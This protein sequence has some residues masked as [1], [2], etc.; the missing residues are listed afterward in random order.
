MRTFALA[1]ALSASSAAYAQAVCP[2]GSIPAPVLGEG[3]NVYGLE[4][5]LSAADELAR[6]LT[7]VGTT[8]TVPP[9]M[10]IDTSGDDIGDITLSQMLNPAAGRPPAVGGTVIS[11]GTI[12]VDAANC[13]TFV[14]D[15]VYFELGEHVIDGALFAVDPTAGTFQVNGTTVTM[16][17]DA[18][19]PSILLGLSANPITIADM[20]GYEGTLVAAEGHFVAGVLEAKVVETEVILGNPVGDSVGIERA[21]WRTNGQVEVRGTVNPSPTGA[22]STFVDIDMGCNGTVENRATVAAGAVVG[23]GEFRYR[24]GG[25]A[26]PTNPGTVCVATELGGTATRDVTQ[27]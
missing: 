20:V 17:T 14:P 13:A 1:L 8:I 25:N 7:V 23:T 15:V 18:R 12:V 22:L 21:Q 2:A 19:F 6:T 10:L 26:F 4:G 16:N 27:R 9:T 5:P 3:A 11:T 24:S